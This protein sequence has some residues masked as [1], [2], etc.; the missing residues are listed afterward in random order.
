MQKQTLINLYFKNKLSMAEIAN[1]LEVSPHKVV[2]WM[3]KYNLK[4]RS[5]SEATY[6]KRN[7]KGDPFHSPQNCGEKQNFLKGL[8]LGLYWGEGT[9]ADKFAVRL[10][11]SDPIVIKVFLKFLKEF[12]KI[13]EKKLKFAIHIFSDINP[14]RALKYW[15]RKLKVSLDKFLK[16]QV[17]NLKRKGTYNRFAKTPQS[18]CGNVGKARFQASLARSTKRQSG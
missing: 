15:S 2:Y 10:S 3:E 14:D 16:P 18:H 1:K 17:I 11:N 13:N 4:R 7:P 9:K 6:V 5:R 12:Y 8:G